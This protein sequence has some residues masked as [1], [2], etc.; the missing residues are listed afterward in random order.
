[1]LE[2]VR[3]LIYADMAHV[4]SAWVAARLG[5]W[6][7]RAVTRAKEEQERLDAIEKDRRKMKGVLD[8]LIKSLETYEDNDDLLFKITELYDSLD[9][10]GS[11]RDSLPSPLYLRPL[12]VHER[13]GEQERSRERR[14]EG[15]CSEE[16]D[17]I[18]R[19]KSGEGDGEAVWMVE[20]RSYA[21][22]LCA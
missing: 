2:S 19:H 12:C 22:I 17:R 7:A 14:W 9:E 18:E 10:D 5:W 15:V 21:D 16:S 1:M 6:L 20:E 11:G 4:V 13:D 3:V 8:E